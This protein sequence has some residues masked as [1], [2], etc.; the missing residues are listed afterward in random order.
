ML[1]FDVYRGPW[2]ELP[3]MGLGVPCPGFDLGRSCITKT[4]PLGMGEE[5]GAAYA[6]KAGGLST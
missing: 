2:S 1:L 3:V 6:R 4:S 5:G